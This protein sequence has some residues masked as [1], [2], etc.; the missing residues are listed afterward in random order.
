MDKLS[1]KELLSIMREQGK[2]LC[3][4]ARHKWRSGK[5][6]PGCEGMTEEMFRHWQLNEQRIDELYW[7]FREV[8]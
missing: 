8:I 4:E 2:L 1:D 6:N 7:K 3:S 5:Y